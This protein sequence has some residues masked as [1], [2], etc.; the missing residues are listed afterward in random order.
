MTH[1]S[2]LGVLVLLVAPSQDPL[3]ARVRQ[4]AYA[5]MELAGGVAHDAAVMG[6]VQAK[7]DQQESAA[8]IGRSEPAR[9]RVTI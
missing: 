5:R 9:H 1:V 7:N 2:A 8:E 3:V 6:F 4:T